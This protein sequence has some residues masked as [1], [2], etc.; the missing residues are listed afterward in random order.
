MKIN[1]E[2]LEALYR[3]QNQA[4]GIKS[5][6]TR[7]EGAF[8]AVLGIQMGFADGPAAASSAAAA[9]QTGSAAQASMISQMLLASQTES[10]N[11]VEDVIQNAFSMASGTL[12][13]WDSYVHA[14]N[15]SGQDGSLREAYALLQGIDGQVAGLKAGAAGVRGQNAG[16]DALINE[17]DVMTTTEKF[18]FNRGDYNSV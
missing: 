11:P 14:L 18:K 2:Q 13:M 5:Q 4:M 9:G 12:D 17:L 3:Q 8:D 7:Q 16:L 6:Q 1:N 10:V 15:A